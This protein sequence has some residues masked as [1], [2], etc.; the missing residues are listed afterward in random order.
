MAVSF[1]DSIGR[2]FGRDTIRKFGAFLQTGGL[3]ISPER[4]AGLYVVV[5]VLVSILVAFLFNVF[6]PMRNMMF[7]SSLFAIK[8]L[9]LASAAFIPMFTILFSFVAVFSLIALFGYVFVVLSADSRKNKVEDALPDFLILASAN[10]RAGMTVDQ[11]LWHAAK[12][13]F[14]LLSEEVQVVAKRAFGGVPFNEAIDYLAQTVNSK[15]LRRTVTLIKQGLASGSSVA[16]ILER[17]AADARDVQ[18]M[19]REI[20]ASLLMYV[21]FILFAAAIGTPFLFAVS[22]KLIM[23]M[24]N[25][26]SQIPT[27]SSGTSFGATSFIHPQPPIV[28][29][30]QFYVFVIISVL[31]TSISA[32]LLIGIIQKGNKRAGLKFL[33]FILIV[34]CIL[35]VIVVEAIGSFVTGLGTG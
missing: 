28:T 13:E 35:F 22:A 14:G 2:A 19:K 17:T 10:A 5:S 30:D 11:A 21:I 34:G 29:S 1:Y 32:S 23:L 20:A 24:E 16:V 18:I 8:P 26:F 3:T 12:P 31:I 9:V 27:S 7:K 25:V 6:E 4:F 33:P 15:I